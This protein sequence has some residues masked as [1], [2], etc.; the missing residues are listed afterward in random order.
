ML[1]KA[2]VN[3]CLAFAV[4]VFPQFPVNASLIEAYYQLLQDLDCSKDDLRNSIMHVLRTSSWFP[5]ISLI[6][7]EILRKPTFTPPAFNALELDTSQV[8]PMPEYVRKLRD[9]M[10][11][12]IDI[13]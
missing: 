11:V 2:D 13:N 9:E 12:S 6:R 5:T 7:E 8:I 3:D 4:A 10:N 1:T